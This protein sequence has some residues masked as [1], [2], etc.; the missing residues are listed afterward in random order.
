MI[1]NYYFKNFRKLVAKYLNGKSTTDE[2]AAIE[3]YYDL[4]KD[5]PDA[6][7]QMGADEMSALDARLRSGISRGMKKEAARQIPL[8]QYPWFRMAAIFLAII[9]IVGLFYKWQ[10]DHRNYKPVGVENIKPTGSDRFVT[11]PDGSKVV[12][13]AGS[14]LSYGKDFNKTTRE[15]TLT[16]EAYFDV[17]HIEYSD[18]ENQSVPKPFTI[19]TGKVKTTVLGTAFGIKAW[20]ESKDITV[21]VSRG[22][23]RVEDENH[24]IA[25]LTEEKQVR[26]NT[27]TTVS[28]KREVK[29]AELVGWAQMDM[30][31]D[32]MPFST[33]AE[34]LGKRYHVN[35]TFNNPELKNCSFTGRFTGT[36]SL[37]E[38]MNTLAATSK[39]TFVID[40][41]NE[42]VVIDGE[43]CN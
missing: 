10:N 23:V 12:L 9:G 31:F 41:R 7:G 2:A 18:G 19:L 27:E 8:Y 28:D 43:K 34:H 30:T 26:Y 22:K 40:D 13:R 21:T 11:L 16:G 33:L 15:V 17:A 4:F 3:Q 20:P 5:E 25:I 35:I 38:V 24:V 36:E 6:T 39:T 29:S 37:E 32:A 42:T 14:N 1:S